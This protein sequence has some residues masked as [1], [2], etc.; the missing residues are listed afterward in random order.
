MVVALERP[1]IT[2]GGMNRKNP[3]TDKGISRGHSR[4][5]RVPVLQR[6]EL[7]HV[8]LP[9]L[10]DLRRRPESFLPTG[11]SLLEAKSSDPL[12]SSSLSAWRS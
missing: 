6:Y 9:P 1:L 10:D 3:D 8:W 4:R 12:V 5:P 2:Y 7:P 11:V